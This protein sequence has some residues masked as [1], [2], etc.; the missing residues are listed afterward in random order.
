MPVPDAGVL[1]DFLRTKD[2]KL[3]RLFRSLPVAVCGVTRAEILTGARGAR[4]RQRLVQFLSAFQQ[5][6]I[7]EAAWDQT[8]E[9]GEAT[10]FFNELRTVARLR[11]TSST[12]NPA[13]LSAPG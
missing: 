9:K 3:D 5:V 12:A 10:Q 2:P 7:P 4:D 6:L 13:P 1:I 11:R 8:T